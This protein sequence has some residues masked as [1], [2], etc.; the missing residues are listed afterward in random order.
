MSAS[1]IPPRA[2]LAHHQA[3]LVDAIRRGP[4]AP[5]EAGSM[6]RSTPAL[7]AVQR[8]E[9]YRN[10][11]RARLLQAFHAIFPGLLHALGEEL[12]DAFALQF[13]ARHPPRHFSVNRVAD[14]FA[15]HLR[16]TRP[17]AAPEADW[18]DFVI[19]LAALESALLQVSE[20][21][22]LEHLPP[23]DAFA[24][25]AGSLDGLLAS[26]PRQAP[27]TRLLRCR[28]PVHAYLQALRAGGMPPLPAPRD[29]A[30]ALTRVDWRLATRELAP[31]QWELLARLNGDTRVDQALRAVAA[32]DLRPVPTPELARRWL[33]NFAAQGL[34]APG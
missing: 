28:H 24:L 34:L 14:G 12:L 4:G 7:P 16:R 18:S 31:V 1:A 15:D 10:A 6:L 30:L 11:Y 27:C 22:G 21:P 8:L 9:I 29:C 23:P 17:A 20:A 32:L 13:L 26:R 33:A 25:R 19:D 5:G 3:W 2:L